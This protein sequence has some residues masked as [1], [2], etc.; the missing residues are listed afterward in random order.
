MAVCHQFNCLEQQGKKAGK[1]P[2]RGR[3]T[4]SKILKE[5]LNYIPL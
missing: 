3:N 5:E 1:Y 2:G 4:I